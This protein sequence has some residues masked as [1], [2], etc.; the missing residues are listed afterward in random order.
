M[1]SWQQEIHG[2]ENVTEVYKIGYEGEHKEL[3]ILDV[4]K[5]H[6]IDLIINTPQSSSDS[7]TDG[8]KIRRCAVE[9]GVSIVT[10]I[11]SAIA[12]ATLFCE[13]LDYDKFDIT[14]VA[15]Y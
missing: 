12:L 1:N 4:I 2:V 11:D 14:D 7:E 9:C 15:S 3:G 5:N 13:D 6:K 10:S 8:F